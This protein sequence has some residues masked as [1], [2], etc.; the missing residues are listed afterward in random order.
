MQLTVFSSYV[1]MQIFL[2]EKAIIPASRFLTIYT[3]LVECGKIPQL[4][5]LFGTLKLTRFYG[6]TVELAALL[7]SRTNLMK[8]ALTL[9][10]PT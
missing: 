9:F 1:N 5:P 4:A 10:Y 3:A 2:K 8:I 7:L 6:K